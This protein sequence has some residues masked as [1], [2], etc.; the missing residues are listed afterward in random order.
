[1]AK[2][3][4]RETLLMHGEILL[5]Y[6]CVVFLVS[7]KSSGLALESDQRLSFGETNTEWFCPVD[8]RHC[9]SSPVA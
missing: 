6:L 9:K 5:I 8:L 3:K 1:M 4:L 2:K 7:L